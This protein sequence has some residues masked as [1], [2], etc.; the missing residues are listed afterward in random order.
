[1]IPHS[2]PVFGEAFQH[3]VGAV[4]ESGHPASG[5]QVE[6]L[7]LEVAGCF[8]MDAAA[9][10]DSGTSA[11]M[12]ALQALKT[13]QAVSRV[14]IPAYACRALAHAVFSVGAEPVSMDCGENLRLDAEKAMA[15]APSLDVV[16]LVHPFG[17]I[18]PMVS[19][20]WPCTVIEDVAQAVGG[21]YDGRTVGGYGDMAVT[22]FYANKPWGGAYG[23]MVLGSNDFSPLC[24]VVRQMRF[25]D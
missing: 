14:G 22:S 19:A 16:I 12:L 23:G 21:S 17:L 15:L 9:A 18:E 25:A 13:R 10:V 11:L 3:A 4:L 5:K 20:E 7:E 8:S 6:A 2:R 1:M 24:D